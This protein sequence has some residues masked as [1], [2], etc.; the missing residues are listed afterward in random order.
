MKVVYLIICGAG[1]AMHAVHFV[2][3]AIYDGVIDV[4]DLDHATGWSRLHEV[5]IVARSLSLT[6]NRLIPVLE[7][8]DRTGICHQLANEDRLDWCH[9]DSE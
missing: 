6:A 7:M 5:M 2:E 1:P 3:A 8:S 4:H 9:G